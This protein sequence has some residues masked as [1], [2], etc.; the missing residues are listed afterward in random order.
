[1]LLPSYL[2]SYSEVQEE[3]PESILSPRS[4]EAHLLAKTKDLMDEDENYLPE[5]PFKDLPLEL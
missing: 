5:P 2:L 3:H 4:T 1:M